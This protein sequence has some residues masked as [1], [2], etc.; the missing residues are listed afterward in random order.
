MQ[1]RF[2]LIGNSEGLS[3]LEM[4]PY[5]MGEHSVTVK[6]PDEAVHRELW[7]GER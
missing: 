4:F 3:M 1:D 7:R 6:G 2:L 5:S